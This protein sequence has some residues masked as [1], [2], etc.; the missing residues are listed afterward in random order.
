V[1]SGYNLGRPLRGALI[2]SFAAVAYCAVAG[3]QGNM[4]FDAAVEQTSGDYGGTVDYDDLY[5]PLTL[6]YGLRRVDLRLTV[7]Y[8]EVDTGTDT[9]VSGLGDVIA[10]FTAYDLWHTADGSLSLGLTG[11]IKF[12]TADETAGLGSGETDYSLQTGMYKSFG[13]S[14]LSTGV[15]YRARGDTATI[16]LKNV[17][18]AY[19]GG[20]HAFSPR[21]RGGAAGLRAR[22][23]AVTRG[24]P[25]DVGHLDEWQAGAHPVLRRLPAGQP[26][27]GFGLLVCDVAGREGGRPGLARVA[28]QA[29]V[30]QRPTG[31]RARRAAQCGHGHVQRPRAHPEV[32]RHSPPRAELRVRRTVLCRTTTC[33]TTSTRWPLRGTRHRGRARLADT[34]PAPYR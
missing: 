21:T 1:S 17:W 9:T 10:G 4:R 18:F 19:V 23:P 33:R 11:K 30:G 7:P 27:S 20:L 32:D 22:R 14:G 28:Q 34:R 31:L 24:E 2:A 13:R 5:V 8:L 16:D 25:D 6:T 12:G 26:A 3:A 15:G 29:S